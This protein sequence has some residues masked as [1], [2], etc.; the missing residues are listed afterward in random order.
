LVGVK[1]AWALIPRNTTV[2]R[3]RARAVSAQDRRRCEMPTGVRRTANWP[4][5]QLRSASPAIRELPASL[6][7]AA[8]GGAQQL[9]THEMPIAG[10]P[11]AAG[12]RVAPHQT[13]LVLQIVDESD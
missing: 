5:P 4:F 11:A 13:A 7:V 8:R 9:A 10:F 1:R 6:V 3:D 2:Q 12:I